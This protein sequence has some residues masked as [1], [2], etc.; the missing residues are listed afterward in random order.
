MARQ[1]DEEEILS[2][3][4]AAN[5]LG[6][7]AELLFQYTKKTFAKSSGLRALNTIERSGS[8]LF[9]TC[10]LNAFDELL[11]G[12]WPSTDGRRPSIP[13]AVLDHLRAESFN[14]CARCGSGIG[15]DTAHIE[16]WAESQS[17]HHANLIRLCSACHR[18]HDAQN[19][20]PTEELRAIKEALVE[21]TRTNLRIRMH[22]NSPVAS[23]PRPIS[24]FV[25]RETEF[26]ILV[27]AI[28]SGRSTMITG[29]GGIGKTQLLVQALRAAE[30]GRPVFWIEIELYRSSADVLTALRVA[31][32]S[33]GIA[34]P[35]EDVA[36]RLDS[37]QACVVLDGVER[38]ALDDIDAF[39]DALVALY[40]A[41]SHAQFLVTSQV[42]LHGLVVDTHLKIGRLDEAASHQILDSFRPFEQAPKRDDVTSLLAFCGGHALS[43]RLAAAL[44]NHYGGADQALAAINANGVAAI[45][46]PARKTQS[47]RTSLQLCL[48][49]AYN[50]LSSD[51][52]QLLWALSEAPA[53]FLTQYLEGDWLE[54]ADP[55]E[56]LAELRRWHLVEFSSVHES[57]TR[58]QVLSPIRA[59][60]TETA[61]K[62]DQSGHDAVIDR[63]AHAFQ[64]M[65]AVFELSY[66]D[67]NETLYVVARYEEELPN[68]LRLL[69][70]AQA[71]RV[72][73]ELGLAAV[74]IVR[75]L[76]RYFF[77]RR[78][79]EQGARV[80]HD[81]AELAVAIGN[82]AR[83]SGLILQLVALADRA[84]DMKLL[85]A[86]LG[87]ADELEKQTDDIEVR[88][89][90]A[91]CRGIAA[92]DEGD[93]LAAERHAR[94]ALEGYRS[95][96]RAAITEQ[97]ANPN[98]KGEET[99]AV[100][101]IHNDISHALGLLGFALLLQERYEE[102]RTAYRHSLQ[103][104]RGASV[105]VNRGQT[106][107]QIGNCEC[108]L[109][110]YKEA[111]RLYLEAGEIFHFVGMEEYLS[112]ALGELGYALLDIDD[113]Y[114]LDAL[115]VQTL[116]AA[117][118][119][120]AK[121]I[122]RVFNPDQS[123][124][125]ARAIGVIRKTFGCVALASL[126]GRGHLLGD[127]CMEISDDLIP[128]DQEI[129]R[130]ERD[131]DERFP[132]SM[133]DVALRLG[134]YAAGAERAFAEN[135]DISREIIN[136]M[137]KAVCNSHS[138]A[139]ETMRIVD[140]LAA[141][142]SRRWELK[143]ASPDRL[144][145]FIRNFDNDIVDYLDLGR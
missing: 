86:G 4:A 49:T 46:F 69:A 78:L 131:G 142:L 44:R 112:N 10:E 123:I 36:A 85:Q 71:N 141:L 66:D 16:P 54:L 8:T 50:A 40:D 104:Q 38:T 25:G 89:D 81:A 125:H 130:G 102:A 42:T 2:P 34:C 61:R 91:M 128:L 28:R 135:G 93:L 24:H 105:G 144:R 129:A 45:S 138:W 14:Q 63:L 122:R 11:S 15:V 62:N 145:E 56:S 75:A 143:G 37:V 92:R 120:L 110:R 19:S 80:M 6:I 136:E 22:A 74:S 106:L 90:I 60:A 1:N 115:N 5:Y 18:E 7:T 31:L 88:A 9:T 116:D 12:Q 97:D 126:T 100:A 39:E 132:L 95:Q 55:V 41:T 109:G 134:F 29:V 58:T 53:G 83:A 98:E 33:G 30:T 113:V 140:W 64:M 79:P 137:L 13:K 117:L 52:R 23:G 101:E 107:H 70:L 108:H 119:D 59:F 82:A 121:D 21:R 72:N 48:Q 20:L 118:S 17:H 57:V 67:P 77:V 76:M 3:L 87:L 84:Q 96:L 65:V 94:A 127:F 27:D 103:H 43:L 73:R 139:Q 47:A 111:A 124:D 99:F 26:S 35:E 114:P 68:F 133:M 51:A 32:G